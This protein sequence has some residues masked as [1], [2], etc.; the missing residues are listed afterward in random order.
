M[1]NLEGRVI[2]RRAGGRAARRGADRSRGHRRAG[3]TRRGRRDS[4]P[5][6]PRGRC[7]TSCAGPPRA[8]RPT[9]RASPTSS[10]AAKDGVFWPCPADDHPG[11]PTP[12][13]RPLR[14]TD[15]RARF[16]PSRTA[17]PRRSPTPSIR[18][19]SRRAAAAAL[20]VRRADPPRRALREAQPEPLVEMHPDL[21][22]AHRAVRR[23]TGS[24]R[25]PPR[26]RRVLV[27]VTETIRPDTVFMPFHWGGSSAANL[28]HQS[29]AG[30]D[31]EDAGVQGLRR[32]A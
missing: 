10:I 13:R 3:P 7:S 30:P 16:I 19:S 20:Q 31:L 18:C 22:E 2:L 25:E 21:A 28:A 6:E 8:A 29:G 23:A 11:T 5:S 27:R 4:S 15:G 1:T 12:L 9:T 24:G 14:D 17:R 26:A 32:A